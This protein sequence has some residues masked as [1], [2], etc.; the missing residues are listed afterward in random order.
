MP[1]RNG[2]L[3]W[4]ATAWSEEMIHFLKDNYRS[5][6]NDELT[7]ALKIGKTVVRNKLRELGLQRMK[8][9]YWCKDQV[10]FLKSHY[11]VLGDVEIMNYFKEHFPKQKGWTRKSI[12]KK[13]AQLQLERTADEINAILKRHHA[14]GGA[15]FTIAQ[16]SSSVNMSDGW[17]AVTMARTNSE[18]RKELLQHPEII[19]A[20][21]AILKLKRSIKEKQKIAG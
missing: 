11:Q 18:L 1:Y 3:V 7:A 20:K 17:I 4:N 8:L 5:M 13:R 15:M 16:N 2:T 6:T 19:D 10:E 14:P 9:E 21:R 12:W